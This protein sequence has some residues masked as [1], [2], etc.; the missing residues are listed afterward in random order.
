MRDNGT[1]MARN[2]CIKLRE[3]STCDS[4]SFFSVKKVNISAVKE[5]WTHIKQN[6]KM[7]R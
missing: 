2:W 3:N 1:G 6:I 7:E 4:F 5:G